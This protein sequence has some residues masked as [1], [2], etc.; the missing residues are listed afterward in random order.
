[1]LCTNQPLFS[2][3]YYQSLP[4]QNTQAPVAATYVLNLQI[5]FGD[6]LE[7]LVIGRAHPISVYDLQVE[8]QQRFNIPVLDQN[9]AYNGMPLT[10]YPPDTSLDTLGILNNSFISLWYKN[11]APNSQQQQQQQQPPPQQLQQQQPPNDYYS[12]RQQVPP[13]YYGDGSQSPRGGGPGDISP[14]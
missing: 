12:A 10:Q 6:R 4:T 9:V 3:N 1:L 14:G 7:G 13:T 5:G 8:L 11:P 2:G